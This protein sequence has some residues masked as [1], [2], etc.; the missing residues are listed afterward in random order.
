MINR[1][2]AISRINK[3]L[4]MLLVDSIALI[5]I[6]LASFSLRLGVWYWPESDLVWVILGAPIIAIPIFIRFGLYRAIIR[7]IGF[8]ALWAVFQAVTLYAL[9]WGVVGFMLAVDG[10]PRSVILINWVLAIL[11]IGGLRMVA[12]WV[13]SDANGLVQSSKINVIIYGAGSAGRQLLTALQQSSEYHP[14]AFI[15]DASELNKQSINGIEI[16]TLNDIKDL[17]SKSGVS[18][19]LLAIP[20]ASRTRRNEI[21]DFLELYPVMVRSLPGVSELAQG[22]VSIADLKEVSIRDLLGRDVVEP[23]EDLLNQNITDKVVLVTGAGGSIGSELCRQIIFLKP[24]A[25]ILY[26]MSELVLYTIEKELSNI[27]INQIDIYPILGSVNNKIRLG[28]VFKRFNV[29]TIY[30]AA[31]YKHVP[32]VEFNNTE[33]VN[34]NVFGALCAAQVAIDSG[35]KTFVLISTDKAV[36]PTNTM[37]ATKRTAELVLQSL[38]AKQSSTKFTMVRFGN[39]LG[40][41]GSVIPL[42]KQQIKTGGPVTVTDKDIIR[43]FMTIPEAVEL[44]I[45]AGAMGQGGDVFVLDMGEPVK[46]YDLA[47]KMIHLTGLEVKDESNPKGDIEIQVTGLR[48]GEK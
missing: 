12:R 26:E 30:H 34:N 48:P 38:A 14:V 36:R 18:E 17:I 8:K 37:G 46:I 33:G 4:V 2:L 32:M 21:I 20:S 19:I 9:V 31:A 6:L 27:G 23:N 41:S 1:L 5:G 10:I 22:K 39:V 45:Q 16:F 35:V 13:L 42:F 7:Y 24:K 40:S 43:Y 15:D 29:D 3:Q 44:V 47:K 28:N 11:A 25:L